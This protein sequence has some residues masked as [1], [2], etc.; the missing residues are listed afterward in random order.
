[1][2]ARAKILAAFS[3][4]PPHPHS[5]DAGT[6]GR[7]FTWGV[8]GLELHLSQLGETLSASDAKGKV[9]IL[10]FLEAL[11][12]QEGVVRQVARWVL[13]PHP[14]CALQG[15]DP[16]VTS[17]PPWPGPAPI[18]PVPFTFWP[19]SHIRPGFKVAS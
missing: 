9:W 13:W 1:M 7:Q 10:P 3:L 6:R 19:Y 5:P 17:V 14:V 15:W 4:R 12:S 18:T 2:G 8:L 16:A 11:L